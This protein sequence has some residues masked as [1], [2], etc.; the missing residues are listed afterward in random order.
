MFGWVSCADWLFSIA[1]WLCC[2]AYVCGL[3]GGVCDLLVLVGFAVWY[4]LL[5]VV[6]SLGLHGGKFAV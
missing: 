1:W 3:D 6:R 2:V 5:A 4:S